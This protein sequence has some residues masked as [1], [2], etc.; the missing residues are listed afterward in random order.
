MITFKQQAWN[1]QLD[2]VIGKNGMVS[3]DGMEVS[4]ARENA[5][6]NIILRLNAG[7]DY[8]KQQFEELKKEI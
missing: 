4:T 1:E 5:L 6:A 2:I 3:V 7:V 8:W